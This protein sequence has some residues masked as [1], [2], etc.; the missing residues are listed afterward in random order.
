MT[1]V[2]LCHYKNNIIKEH[3]NNSI[4]Q[5]H[6][7]ILTDSGT[8][9]DIARLDTESESINP[10]KNKDTIAKEGRM[11]VL[12]PL[13][14]LHYSQNI[15]KKTQVAFLLKCDLFLSFLRVCV[16]HLSVLAD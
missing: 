8:T 5:N 6:V 14:L 11:M 13:K 2:N 12:Q 15:C 1:F 7:I 3:K 10:G 16:S 4:S 9:V